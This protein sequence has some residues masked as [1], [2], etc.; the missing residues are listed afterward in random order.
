M[1]KIVLLEPEHPGNIG[2]VARVM[3]NFGHTHLVLINPKCNHLSLE[4]IKF[5]KHGGNILKS[6]K[7]FETKDVKKILSKFHTVIA[8]TSKLGTDYNVPRSPIS[9]SQLAD[10]MPKKTGKKIALLFGRES[11]GLYNNEIDFADF[12]VTIPT[13]KKYPALNLSQ[14]VGIILYELGKEKTNIASHI[15]L[16]TSTEKNQIQK[17]LN[18]IFNSLSWLRPSHRKTQ[19]VIWKKIMGKSFLTKREAFS[20]MGFL[21]K[22]M[23]KIK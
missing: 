15:T 23:K 20:V 2:S 16:A 8:T 12:T 18:Q 1:I 17:M 22:V 6:A 4:A 9:P 7:V 14:S 11:K 19:E 5:A 13:N 10:K 3:A 21:R